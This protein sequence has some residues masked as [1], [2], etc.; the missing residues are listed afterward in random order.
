MKDERTLLLNS[1]Y[2]PLRVVNTQEKAL[3][4]IFRGKVYVVET[5]GRVIRTGGSDYP[6]PSVVALIKYEPK[7]DGVRFKRRNVY[8]RDGHQ[9][10]YCGG[11][12]PAGELSYDHV[13]PRA[14][15]AGGFVRA[16][17][18]G[19]RIPVTCWENIVTACKPCNHRKAD[20]TPKQAGMPLLFQPKK[21]L[22]AAKGVFRVAGDVPDEWGFYLI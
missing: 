14:Q 5:G 22:A 1:D 4:L 6:F 12:Y 13:V 11:V 21:P 17:G 18:S 16:W 3:D 10:A 19:R 9:C 7:H 20:R 15:G 2:L 8:Q